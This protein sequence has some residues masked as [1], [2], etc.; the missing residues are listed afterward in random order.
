MI[1]ENFQLILKIQ[2]ELTDK[3]GLIDIPVKVENI[4]EEA[5]LE[6]NKNCIIISER[7]INDQLECIKA[8]VHELRHIYQ[9]LCVKYDVE[10]EIHRNIWKEELQNGKAKELYSFV[11]IDAYAFTKYYLLKM[12]NMKYN[13]DDKQ[14]DEITD[15]YLNKFFVEI[16]I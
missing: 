13:Y 4:D 16:E 11:E 1:N 10:L 12:Y 6:I 7:I 2:E 5:R 15:I 9:I 14:L 3:L 8:I